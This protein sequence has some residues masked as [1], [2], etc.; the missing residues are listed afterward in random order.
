METTQFDDRVNFWMHQNPE[1]PKPI[2]LEI[3]NFVS[4]LIRLI[5]T[6]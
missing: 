6:P 3:N 1:A 5:G 4:P 2:T